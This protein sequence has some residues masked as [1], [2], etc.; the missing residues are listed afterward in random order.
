LGA[1]VEI[2]KRF[3]ANPDDPQFTPGHLEPLEG[4]TAPTLVGALQYVRLSKHLESLMGLFCD[5][6][7]CVLPL[8]LAQGGASS[9]PRFGARVAD[10]FAGA[11]WASSGARCGARGGEG[12]L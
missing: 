3:A 10:L 6:T 1:V 9:G 12:Q 5:L 11:R 8:S 4:T 7:R 2:L